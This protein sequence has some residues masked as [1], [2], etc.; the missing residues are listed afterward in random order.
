VYEIDIL[1][2]LKAGESYEGIICRFVDGCQALSRVIFFHS[3][4]RGGVYP[5]YLHDSCTISL[6]LL[7]S[8]QHLKILVVGFILRLKAEAFSSINVM[9]NILSF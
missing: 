3:S 8:L 6:I 5:R 4:I 9:E 7:K 1:T 2:R